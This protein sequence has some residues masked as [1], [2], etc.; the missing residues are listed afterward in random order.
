MSI[1]FK[2]TQTRNC[3]SY[4]KRHKQEELSILKV[5]QL[6]PLQM[7]AE[8]QL[9]S[10]LKKTQ[11]GPVCGRCLRGNTGK[12]VRFDLRPLYAQ[13]ETLERSKRRVTT[14][15]QL[16][17]GQYVSTSRL[18]LLLIEIRC[19]IRFLKKKYKKVNSTW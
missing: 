10:S 8:I 14:I 13:L 6:I 19:T 5:T 9:K 11:S 16:L 3:L 12:R 1:L 15:Q 7:A 2:E 17:K 4:L 18:I